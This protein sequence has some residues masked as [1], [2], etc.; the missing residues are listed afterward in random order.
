[1]EEPVMEPPAVALY[2]VARLAREHSVKVLLSGEGGD[3]AFGGYQNYRNLLLLE[4]L[5][6]GFGPLK[7]LL[8]YG[9]QLLGWAGW[10][11]IGRYVDLIDPKLSE[12]YLSRTATAD[13]SLNQMKHA[14]YTKEFADTIGEQ[15]QS[16]DTPT[17]RFFEK[18]N[19]QPD[20]NQM[21]YVDTKTWLPNDLL[22]KA[23]KMTMA[24]SVELR[25]PLLDFQVLEF[26]ASLPPRFKVFG[27]ATK[28]ILKAA[29]RE[30]VP[31]EILKRKKTGF[32][33]P[34]ERWLKTE[35]KEFVFDT[36]LSKNCALSSYFCRDTLLDFLEMH[37]RGKGY[38]QEIFSLLV[39]E[40]CNKQ[41]FNGSFRQLSP[42]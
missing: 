34:Y 26:A 38:S 2:F 29:L 14:L 6:S 15:K 25:V 28:R 17:R 42:S 19:G 1:M 35:L 8:R 12:Y 3:E 11:R 20:L 22:V 10:R 16:S 4:S 24:T 37:Q 30:S 7:G 13:R 33:V 41:F 18:L 32:P 36:L 9:F 5:K 23:D 39:I 21:L 31:Q 40:L 27:W